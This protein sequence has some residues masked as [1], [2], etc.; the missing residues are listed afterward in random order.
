MEKLV[1]AKFNLYLRNE[2]KRSSKGVLVRTGTILKCNSIVKGELVERIDDWY[3]DEN[4]KYFLAGGVEEI[5]DAATSVPF[6]IT[7][8]QLKK[9][10][11]TLSDDKCKEYLPC[12]LQTK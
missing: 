4:G 8:E 10:I 11:P 6:S 12:L 1:R 5:K 3:K 7:A 2:P 9:I